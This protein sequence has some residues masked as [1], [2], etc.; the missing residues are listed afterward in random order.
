MN[1][2]LWSNY[3]MRSERIELIDV[4]RF[5]LAISVM[6]FHF[7]N[8][9]AIT[10]P[11]FE[12]SLNSKQIVV[13]PFDHILGWFYRSGDY[14]VPFF[15]SISGAVLGFTY[16]TPRIRA[17]FSNFLFSRIFR[18]YPL[19]VVT[20]V[21]VALI[22]QFSEREYETHLIYA[23][24]NLLNFILHLLFLPGFELTSEIGFNAPVWSVSAELFTY[25]L[26]GYF[27]LK[28]NFASLIFIFLSFL[29]SQ[30]S[31]AIFDRHPVFLCLN[32]FSL[33]LL[34]WRLNTMNNFKTIFLLISCL[35]VS[36]TFGRP[37]TLMLILLFSIWAL[38]K[39]DKVFGESPYFVNHKSVSKI[40]K[41]LG[42]LTYGIYLWHIPIQMCIIVYFRYLDVRLD[43]NLLRILLFIW[44]LIT[45]LMSAITL[46]FIER[47]AARYFKA[48]LPNS[49][50]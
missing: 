14:A 13:P 39:L 26:F 6:L 33:G 47:P 29:L 7:R 28:R 43:A 36:I 16:L 44:I 35:V 12:A 50:G 1:S 2:S 27:C 40:S 20:L 18:L 15:W 34:A 48:K 49:F 30:L 3:V 38:F 8:F 22:Q 11:F 19:H 21:C 4:V 17:K 45:I 41:S 23:G 46:R 5:F 9:S 24:N 37:S 42:D 31:F 32:Y 10:S 25:V